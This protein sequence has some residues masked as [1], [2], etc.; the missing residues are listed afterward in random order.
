MKHLLLLLTV[1]SI[2]ASAQT[3]FAKHSQ[4]TF[5][6]DTLHLLCDDPI[7]K[8]TYRIW[9]TDSTWKGIYPAIDWVTPD[10]MN[11]IKKAYAKNEMIRDKS[12]IAIINSPGTWVVYEDGRVE[13]AGNENLTYLLI[14]AQESGNPACVITVP[15]GMGCTLRKTDNGIK[16]NYVTLNIKT[17]SKNNGSN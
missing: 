10:Q 2:T 1:I 7:A 17:K 15:T 16:Y 11:R 6:K 8:L 9:T 13:P 3:Q 5:A 12:I 4:P 14:K